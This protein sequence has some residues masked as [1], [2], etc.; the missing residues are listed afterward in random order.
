MM[1]R[2]AKKARGDRKF[3]LSDI[4]SGKGVDELH[5][6]LDHSVFFTDL[7]PA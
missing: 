6:W 4:R 3:I 7:V 1:A 2:D 5:A